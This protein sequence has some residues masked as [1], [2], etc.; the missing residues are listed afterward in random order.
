[1]IRVAFAVLATFE[2]LACGLTAQQPVDVSA[3]FVVPD[4]Y[5]TELWAQSPQLFNPTAMDIDARGRIWVTEAVNYRRFHPGRNPGKKHD[6]GDRVVIL[7]DTDGDGRCDKSKV[8]V[9][10]RELLAPLGILV[11]G[12]RV[13]VSCSPHAIVYTDSDG[14]DV[15]DKREVLLTGFGGR[16]HDHGLHSFVAGPDGKLYFN[17]G[18]AG[19]HSVTARDGWTL[20]SG[21][22]YGSKGAS[23]IANR[24][25]LRSDDGRVWTGGLVLRCKQDGSDLRVLAHNFRNPYEV[26]LDSFAS[27]WISDNDD[28]GN[29]ATRTLWVM[30][31][32][33]YGYFGARGSRNWRADRRSGQDTWTAHWHQDDPG[34]SPAGY[35]NGAGGPTGVCVYENGALPRRFEGSVLNADAGAGCVYAHSPRMRGA[36]YA[37]TRRD[38]IRARPGSQASRRWFRPSDVL[39]GNDGSVFVCD[40]YDPGVG[41]HQMRDK[42]GGGRILRIVPDSWRD[43]AGRVV[44]SAPSNRVDL[45][46]VEGIE[47]AF[48]GPAASPRAEAMRRLHELPA[49]LKRAWLLSRATDAL[50]RD[51]DPRAWARTL[52]FA[53]GIA[54]GRGSKLIAGQLDHR[55]PRIRI[56]ALRALRA[57]ASEDRVLEACEELTTDRD[58]AVRREV[59]ITLASISSL[60]TKARRMS[61]LV[62]LAQLHWPGDRA[63]LEAIGV[64]ARGVEGELVAE[65]LRHSPKLADAKTWTRRFEELAWRL[66]PPSLVGAFAARAQHRKLDLARR[67]RALDA[68]AFVNDRSAAAAMLDHALGGPADTRV[69]AAQW[70]RRRNEGAW[71]DF[72]LGSELAALDFGS[73][74]EVWKSPWIS[75]G[76]TTVDVDVRGADALW[77]VVDSGKNDLARLGRLDRATPRRCQDRPR[78]FAHGSRVDRRI[79]GLGSDRR[80]QERPRRRAVDRWQT[81]RHRDRDARRIEHL[82]RDRPQ[83][84]VALSSSR[85]R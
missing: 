39:V 22:I 57:C 9:Q 64:A 56:V 17:V 36:G 48:D 38:L 75:K 53:A 1:M 44:A 29:Q 84:L 85:R 30:E 47:R 14:D 83:A 11:L 71:R 72:G 67:R 19:P 25:G 12:S 10:D 82:L 52:W 21:S 5:R 73:A 6:K 4:G 68:L 41:G 76:S 46:K 13:I 65:L 15:P 43:D 3:D 51:A 8:F 66:H 63:L 58:R 78:A 35:R 62:R 55:D 54:E 24:P 28:D 26:A 61:V 23:G 32:G 2:L 33:D 74:V 81:L 34:V 45:S 37:M 77:L 79:D 80:Q 42:K 59:A 16:D 50:D 20:R 18:N 69:Y 70:M 7:E 31:G 27:L 60:S 40:W 49:A